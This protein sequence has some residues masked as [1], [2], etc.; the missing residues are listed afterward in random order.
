MSL[1]SAYPCLAP[2]ARL[3][4]MRLAGPDDLPKVSSAVSPASPARP[5][6]RLSLML[7]ILY[8][9]TIHRQAIRKRR[10]GRHQVGQV[11]GDEP[12]RQWVPHSPEPGVDHEMRHDSA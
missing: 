8:R 7:R 6:A 4:R 11:R 2:S 1:V 3:D 9:L 10:G 12:A 5:P